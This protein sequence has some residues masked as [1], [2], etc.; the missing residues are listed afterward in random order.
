MAASY[1]DF[2]SSSTIISI[3]GEE[4]LPT[5]FVVAGKGSPSEDAQVS[6]QEH[7]MGKKQESSKNLLNQSLKNHHKKRQPARFMVS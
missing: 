4:Y 2:L 7:P 5:V 3:L 1:Q 6:Q